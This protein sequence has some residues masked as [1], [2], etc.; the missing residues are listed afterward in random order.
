MLNSGLLDLHGYDASARY[1]FNTAVGAFAIQWESSYYARFDIEL[2]RGSGRRSVL[3]L[4]QPLEPGFRL[5]SNLDL[6][7]QRGAWAG[8][9]QLR[10]YGGLRE[11]CVTPARAGTAGLCSDPATPSPLDPSVPLNR[12]DARVYVDLQLAWETPWDGR[13]VFG[14]RNALDRDPPVSYAGTANSFDA[15]Y[16]V[17]GRFWY[18]NLS[19]RW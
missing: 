15:A 6:S 19:Q 11:S 2:P 16:P 18:V 12:L 5:R 3:G 10:Y 4:L 13:Y 9:A 1:Q 17:P 8:S 14:V 7:W